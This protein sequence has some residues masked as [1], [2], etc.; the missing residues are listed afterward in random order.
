MMTPSPPLTH[1]VITSPSPLTHD[2]ITSPSPSPR[3]DVVTLALAR[4]QLYA[5]VLLASACFGGTFT[6]T[7]VLTA[8]VSPALTLLNVV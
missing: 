3:D 6:L 4:G 8:E 7:V 1:D 5:G 2:V